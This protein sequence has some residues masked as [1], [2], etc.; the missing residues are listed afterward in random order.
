MK[1]IEVITTYD[2]FHDCETCGS[3]WA[4][5]GYVL[6]DGT[7]VVRV[8]PVAHCYGGT[9]VTEEELLVLALEKLGIE[10]LV[11]GDKPQITCSDVRENLGL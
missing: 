10:V 4:E 8:T 2:D 5:G 11:D 6:V 3:S 9:S 7:E 1:R